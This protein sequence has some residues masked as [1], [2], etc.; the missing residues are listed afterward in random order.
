[1]K[2]VRTIHRKYV[3]VLRAKNDPPIPPTSCSI[4]QAE[5]DAFNSAILAHSSDPAYTQYMPLYNEAYLQELARRIIL[6][7]GG[8]PDGDVNSSSVMIS[9]ARC[10]PEIPEPTCGIC[11]E[12]DENKARF[13]KG[14]LSQ[15]TQTRIKTTTVP[16]PP[17]VTTTLNLGNYLNTSGWLLSPDFPI[18]FSSIMYQGG[19][20]P[21]TLKKEN[22]QAE[23][24]SAQF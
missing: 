21:A 3:P 4:I 11:Y 17:P 19:T 8:I 7:S 1:M 2:D 22:N 18:Y 24:N 5:H 14:F 12:L 13:V 23:W 10:L 16:G 20:S 6:A 15:M 9:L